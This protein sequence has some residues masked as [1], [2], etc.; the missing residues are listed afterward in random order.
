MTSGTDR[1]TSGETIGKLAVG[2]R[3]RALIAKVS[4]GNLALAII[5]GASL[6]V[7]AINISS[8]LIEAERAGR[9][10]HWAYPTTLEVTSVVMILAL[11]PLIDWTL[12]RAAPGKVSPTTL[13]A[14]HA[15]MT[16][17]YSLLHVLGMAVLRDWAFAAQGESYNFFADGI[18]LPLVYEWRKDAFTYIS[19]ASTWW[20]L[21]TFL[22]TVGREPTSPPSGESAIQVRDG[23]VSHFLQPQD[24]SHLAAAGNYVVLHSVTGEKTARGTLKQ[25]SERLGPHGFV[26]IHRSALVNPSAIETVKPTG[27]GDAEITLRNGAT[28]RASRRYRAALDAARSID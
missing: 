6:L 2:Q 12:K 25:W 15:A 8:L 22:P 13:V 20:A 19:M 23:A 28:L 11:L 5:V 18:M 26:Q 4:T 3:L 1:G 27:A 9:A 24:I 17:P 14:V 21:L 7:T 16:V 10:M